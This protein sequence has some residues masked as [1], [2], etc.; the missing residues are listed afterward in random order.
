M[1]HFWHVLHFTISLISGE[2][3]KTVQTVYPEV[4]KITD[5][6][7]ISTEKRPILDHFSDPFW[8]SE[9]EVVGMWTRT[10]GIPG[11]PCYAPLGYSMC[12]MDHTPYQPW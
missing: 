6:G 8:G 7:P 4:L 9:Q 5:F 3:V 11:I 12:A 1:S 2:R 10:Q